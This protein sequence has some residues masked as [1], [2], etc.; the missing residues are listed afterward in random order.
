M[1]FMNKIIVIYHVQEV[2]EGD[3]TWK[4]LSESTKIQ[5][6]PGFYFCCVC[7]SFFVFR[8]GNVVGWEEGCMARQKAHHI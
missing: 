5:G 3:R 4:P 6:T 8:V 2:M 1:S 7:R